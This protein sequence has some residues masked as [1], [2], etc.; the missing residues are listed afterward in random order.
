MTTQ[1]SLETQSLTE[2]EEKLTDFVEKKSSLLKKSLED[3]LQEMGK[4]VMDCMKRRDNHLKSLFCLMPGATSTPSITSTPD[5][6]LTPMLHQLP[7]KMAVK[8]EFLKFGSTVDEDPITYLEK[9][10]EY[11][12]VHP[13]N[14]A[15]ILATL[16][17]VLTHTAKDWWVA[18]K[19]QVKT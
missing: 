1:S 2:L 14:D 3:K 13:M 9:C 5:A 4:A 15:E 18:E 10:A 12:A 17:S 6:Q 8:I 19:A 11:L 16:P 7:Y